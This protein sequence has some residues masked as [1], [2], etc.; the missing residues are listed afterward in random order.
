MQYVTSLGLIWSLFPLCL[1]DLLFVYKCS[2]TLPK[3]WISARLYDW[4]GCLL[5]VQLICT[6]AHFT[7]GSGHGIFSLK[8]TYWY[9][10]HC[11]HFLYQSKGKY[12]LCTDDV[13]VT[14]F[15]QTCLYDVVCMC[16]TICMLANV[17]RVFAHL[18]LCSKYVF[19]WITGY[20]VL[21]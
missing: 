9:W 21:F 10:C 3:H 20:L 15:A 11:Y 14:L 8:T 4:T 1:T 7:S 12:D 2:S 19:R 17:F 16:I 18:S 5:R 6:W 13:K